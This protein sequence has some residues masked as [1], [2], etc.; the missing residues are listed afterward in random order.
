VRDLVRIV[1]GPSGD[2]DSVYSAMSEEQLEE[3]GLELKDIEIEELSDTDK[4]GLENRAYEAWSAITKAK[5]SNDIEQIKK[6]QEEFEIVKN[7][8]SNE[9][10]LKVL[11]SSKGL[12]FLIV[13]SKASQDVD[14]IRSNVTKNIRNAIKKDI[15]PNFPQLAVHLNQS[16]STGLTCK[17]NPN[18]HINWEISKE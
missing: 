6:K 9:Y 11:S 17:Y 15:E 8:F 10:G 3:E 2:S 16:I 4:E 5:K 7:H 12:K 14:K 13:R 18:P 1:K